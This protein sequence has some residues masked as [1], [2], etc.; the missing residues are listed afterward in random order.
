MLELICKRLLLAIPTLFL[1]SMMV[2]SSAE[3]AARRSGAGHGG[4]RARPGGDR[5][6]ARAVPPE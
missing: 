3:T 4:G 5:S 6:T 1:V 2:F